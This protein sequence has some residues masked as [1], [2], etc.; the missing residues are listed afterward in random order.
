MLTGECEISFRFPGA[1]IGVQFNPRDEKNIL[2]CPLKAA[3]LVVDTKAFF[4]TSIMQPQV[5]CM[6]VELLRT[7]D[8]EVGSHSNLKVELVVTV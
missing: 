6:Q 4:K 5:I 3:P 7:F 1:I 8:K 2:V